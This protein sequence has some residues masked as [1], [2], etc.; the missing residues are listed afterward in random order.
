[1]ARTKKKVAEALAA[2]TALEVMS[3]SDIVPAKEVVLTEK[4]EWFLQDVANAIRDLERRNAEQTFAL[5]EQLALAQAVLP[6]KRFGAWVKKNCGRTTK[7]AKYHTSVF[8]K[9]ARHKETLE[10][11]AVSSTLMFALATANDDGRVDDVVA[12]VARGETVT[13]AKAKVMLQSAKQAAVA[14]DPLD[15]PGRAGFKKV[16]EQRV[17]FQ[18]ATFYALLDNVLGHVESAVARIKEGKRVIKSELAAAI[19]YDSRHAHDLF[20]LTMAPYYVAQEPF[21]NWK[22]TSIDASTR[23]GQ[24]Q[25]MLHRLGSKEQWP[26]LETFSTWLVE[27]VRVGLLFAIK[28]EAPSDAAMV[29]E[30]GVEDEPKVTGDSEIV[31]TEVDATT[32]SSENVVQLTPRRPKMALAAAE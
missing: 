20:A 1:M 21:V 11:A 7:W 12:M 15:M 19:E 8:H 22:T 10:T 25:K 2:S 16:A 14:I 27:E 28:E 6:P 18:M 13:A 23:W 29:S 3:K 26:G 32:A 4:Q 31:G 30:E 17:K 9:L 5:G 24:F